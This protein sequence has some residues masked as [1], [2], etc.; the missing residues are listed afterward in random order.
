MNRE[1]VL[2][3]WL[4][5]I[6]QVVLGRDVLVEAVDFCADSLRSQKEGEWEEREVTDYYPGGRIRYYCTACG[7]WNTYGKSKY[8][9]SCGAKMKMED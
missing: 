2:Q 7:D 3:T 8:C 6:K 9:P 4:P 5:I 1:D